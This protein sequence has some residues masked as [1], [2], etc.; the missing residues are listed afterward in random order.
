MNVALLVQDGGCQ[1]SEA[2]P[3][4]PALVPHALQGPKNSV[5]AHGLVLV[6]G[7]REYQLAIA[8]Y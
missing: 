8:G 6:I 1:A 7:P 5:I 4:H 3:C 2:V